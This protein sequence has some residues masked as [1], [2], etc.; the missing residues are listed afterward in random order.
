[1]HRLSFL[2]HQSLLTK[3]TILNY[4]KSVKEQFLILS[5]AITIN[6]EIKSCSLWITKMTFDMS[7]KTTNYRWLF[8]IL[9]TS[10]ILQKCKCHS[11]L[12]WCVWQ[13]SRWLKYSF[14]MFYLNCNWMSFGISNGMF[15]SMR[16]MIVSKLRDSINQTG[17]NDN[18]P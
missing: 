2:R 18:K 1:M 4:F 11:G 5:S 14:A 15:C 7:I 12:F 6:E 3:Q 13:H 9:Q 10:P 8:V 17:K 16:I